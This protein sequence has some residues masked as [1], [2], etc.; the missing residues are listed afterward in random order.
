VSQSREEFGYQVRMETRQWL[1]IDGTM[2]NEVS[3]QI[4]NGDPRGVV[5]LGSSIRQAGW[6]QIPGWPQDV[7]GFETW[8]APGQQSTMTL[9]GSQWALV[10]SALEHWATVSESVEGFGGPDR[11]ED[12]ERSLAIAAVIRAQ[13]IEQGWSAR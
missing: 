12:A 8:P 1:I 4:E 11:A 7:K 9:S 13:L 2:D 10:L 6:D 3:T 5:D